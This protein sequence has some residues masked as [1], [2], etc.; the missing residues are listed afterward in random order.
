MMRD[1][2]LIQ[3]KKK[4]IFVGYSKGMKGFKFWDLVSMKLVIS[5]D[6]VFD[7]QSMLPKIVETT[8][9]VSDGISLSSM[10]V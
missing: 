3:S 10:E 8:L 5:R 2:N 7:E 1:I 9:S 6:I 4:C